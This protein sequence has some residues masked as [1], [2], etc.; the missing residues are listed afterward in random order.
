MTPTKCWVALCKISHL[1][2]L[3]VPR[4]LNAAG[5]GFHVCLTQEWICQ[6][7]ILQDVA[8]CLHPPSWNPIQ[9]AMHKPTK[10]NKYA[11]PS[12]CSIAS[13]QVGARTLRACSK[14]PRTTTN[15]CWAQ[16]SLL[17]TVTSACISGQKLCL[18]PSPLLMGQEASDLERL[19]V[20]RTSQ[21][22]RTRHSRL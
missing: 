18:L 7:P 1:C 11:F 13:S 8:T 15:F 12:F 5:S 17:D 9:I 19:Q 16:A 4:T 20:E 10:S 14:Q 6:L 22:P 3:Q 2:F 21:T